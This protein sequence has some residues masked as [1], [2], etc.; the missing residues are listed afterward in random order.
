MKV[1]CVNENVLDSSI[2]AHVYHS[3]EH[4]VVSLLCG[5]VATTLRRWF[6]CK[7]GVM[8]YHHAPL[9]P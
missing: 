8:N 7:K 5:E 4:F 1:L 3:T 2:A 9:L 6:D